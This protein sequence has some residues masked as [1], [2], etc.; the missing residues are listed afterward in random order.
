MAELVE[1]CGMPFDKLRERLSG[2]PFDRLWARL[3]TQGGLRHRTS[4]SFKALRGSLDQP[5]GDWRLTEQVLTKTLFSEGAFAVACETR[6]D[7]THGARLALLHGSLSHR[8]AVRNEA[9]WG[10]L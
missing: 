7:E 5:S 10:S 3:F 9:G 2:A 1:A 8:S 4:R 6:P